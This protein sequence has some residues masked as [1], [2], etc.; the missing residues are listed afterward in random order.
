[1][2]WG[3][4][5]LGLPKYGDA[6][7]NNFPQDWAV[8]CF[9]TTF[10]DAYPWLDKLFA[11]GKCTQARIHLCWSPTHQY[12]DFNI[13]EIT[14]LSHRYDT[15]AVKYPNV[16]IELSPFCEHQLKNPDKYLQ[17]V[18]QQAPHCSLPVNCPENGVWSATFKNEVHASG[19]PLHGGGYNWSDD[20]GI[21]GH[22]II[23]YNVTGLKNI[24][25]TSDVFYFWAARFN[26]YYHM[27]KKGDDPIAIANR[28]GWPDAKFIRAV[29][30]LATDKGNTHLPHK[31]IVKSNSENHGTGDTKA[32]KLCLISPLQ[33]HN[34]TIALRL[35][36]GALIDSLEFFGSYDDGGFRYYSKHMGY[37][38]A[39]LAL[40][41]QGD[42]L[43][44]VFMDGKQYGTINPSF[45]DNY[46]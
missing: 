17:I 4:D 38:V 13:P 33:S 36:S 27:P 6:A 43:V 11:T 39:Q 2:K 45:Y 32:E 9:A 18:Q 20:G 1:M 28:H 24:H 5:F 26:G 14:Q 16:K 31:W 35:R 34:K 22:D 44:N 42:S 21:R 29:S 23:D 12:G 15:L 8:G 46:F 19:G 7:I 10:G 25:N 40:K 3:L 41:S 37:E 30:F